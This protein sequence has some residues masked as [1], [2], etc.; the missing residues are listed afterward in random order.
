MLENMN[1]DGPSVSEKVALSVRVFERTGVALGPGDPAF[2]IVE[3]ARFVLLDAAREAANSFAARANEL[4][5]QIAEA[6]ALAAGHIAAKGRTEAL[7]VFAKARETIDGEARRAVSQ[8]KGQAE[9]SAEVLAA[10]ATDAVSKRLR[11]YRI[12]STLA[13]AA[14]AALGGVVAGSELPHLLPS[15]RHALASM[16]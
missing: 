14:F 6:G 11:S 15:V 4:P 3:L 9:R 1:M 10:R 7:D 5:G 8:I 12:V 2:A 13:I 16:F